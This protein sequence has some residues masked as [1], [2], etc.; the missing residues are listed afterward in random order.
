M[1]ALELAAAVLVSGIG[2]CVWVGAAWGAYLLYDA[3]R[4]NR[5]IRRL[6]RRKP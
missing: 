3:W 1:S 6:T 2:A 5:E 4:C